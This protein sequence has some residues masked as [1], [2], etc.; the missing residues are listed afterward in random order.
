MKIL[1]SKSAC[2]K[3]KCVY[4]LNC[5]NKIVSKIFLRNVVQIKN[6]VNEFVQSSFNDNITIIKILKI[7]YI[8]QLLIFPKIEIFRRIRLHDSA[9]YFFKTWDILTNLSTCLS[10][11]FCKNVDINSSICLSFLFHYRFHQNVV[12]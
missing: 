9:S 8:Y 5:Q 11:S 1:I 4:L 6:Y 3:K 7:G 12:K 2:I 10:F